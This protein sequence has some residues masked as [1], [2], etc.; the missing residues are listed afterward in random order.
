LSFR[1]FIDPIRE[2]DP[3]INNEYPVANTGLTPKIY[4]R[5][6]NDNIDPPLPINPKIKPTKKAPKYPKTELDP[7]HYLSKILC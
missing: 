1:F 6:G 5:I 3:T 4:T 7:L 2:V